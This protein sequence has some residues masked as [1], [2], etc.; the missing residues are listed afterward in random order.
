MI[1]LPVSSLQ[2]IARVMG[3]RRWYKMRREELIYLI[4]NNED[5]PLD[6]VLDIDFFPLMFGVT[7]DTLHNIAL[8]SWRYGLSDDR[9]VSV[10]RAFSE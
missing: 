9:R 5:Y 4:T 1:N 10:I 3:V 7:Y 8:D 6:R 2:C